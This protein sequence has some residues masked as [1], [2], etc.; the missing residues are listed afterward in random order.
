MPP[1]AGYSSKQRY[2]KITYQEDVYDTTAPFN[3]ITDTNLIYNC[4]GCLP[5][6]GVSG[7]YMGG[8]VSTVSGN[9]VASAQ[10]NIDV[11][12]ITSNRNVPIS[13]ARHGKVNPVD[14]L[15]LKTRNEQQC[16]D[17]LNARHSKM[18][19]PGMFYRGVPINRFYDPIKDPQA[20]IPVFYSSR[21][22]VNTSLEAKNNFVPSLPRLFENTSTNCCND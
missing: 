7:G 12:S 8:G 5:A 14:I 22:F 10:Q 18:S 19:D 15:K 6:Y 4:A 16:F 17:T 20:N 1:N 3:Y 21:Q 9:V 13:R 2:D 11:D